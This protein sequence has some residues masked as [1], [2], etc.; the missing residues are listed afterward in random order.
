MV[1]LFQIF[2]FLPQSHQ[3]FDAQPFCLLCQVVKILPGP[4]QDEPGGSA[5]PGTGGAAAGCQSTGGTVAG[6]ERFEITQQFN[7]IFSV[8]IL[9]LRSSPFS[10]NDSC[11]A[12][13]VH[14]FTF[15]PCP[16][17]WPEYAKTALLFS[18]A[19]LSMIQEGF[20]INRTFSCSYGQL[21]TSAYASGWG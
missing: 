15:L 8:K 14:F 21:Q 6:M 9:W 20:S 18:K 1:G 16:R 5:R 13:L 17:A 4:P 19:V 11:S 3:C 12:K 7:Q 10:Q 2:P